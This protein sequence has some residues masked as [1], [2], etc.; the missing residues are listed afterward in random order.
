MVN[1]DT[2]NYTIIVCFINDV[3]K[4]LICKKKR[5]IR[6]WVAAKSNVGHGSD[7]LELDGSN[8]FIAL[9]RFDDL[10]SLYALLL[11]SIYIL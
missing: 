1:T 4:S 8:L 2:H 5:V 7:D 9:Q 6:F 11:G 3:Q 10:N